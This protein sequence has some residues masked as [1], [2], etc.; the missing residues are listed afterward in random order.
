MCKITKEDVL[1]TY[2]R[3]APLYDFVFGAVL[4]P[5]RNKLFDLVHQISPQ[6]ILEVG[7]GTG[8]TLPNYPQNAKLVGVDISPEMLQRAKKRANSCSNKDIYLHVMNAENLGFPDSSF[9]CV[10]LP[11]VLSV[12]PNPFALIS[13]LRRVCK[14]NGSIIIINHFSG[15]KRWRMLEHLV[16]KLS[17]KVGF[18]SEFDYDDNILVH[19]WHIDTVLP[20]NLFNLFKLIHIINT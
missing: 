8:I 4:Q 16:G 7:V 19:D 18:H 11:Y 3:Y 1:H 5:G 13:E 2:K 12:T 14:T 15:S 17:R 9:D 10:V 20:V 6:S